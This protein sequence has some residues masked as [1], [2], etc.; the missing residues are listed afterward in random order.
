MLPSHR[1]QHLQGRTGDAI[2]KYRPCH[3]LACSLCM[4]AL[5]RILI[6]EAEIMYAQ[7]AAAPPHH[8]RN[9]LHRRE[10]FQAW[11]KDTPSDRSPFQRTAWSM[12]ASAL[13]PR[14][15]HFCL[16]E[17][18]SS[19]ETKI[20]GSLPSSHYNSLFPCCVCISLAL[21]SLQ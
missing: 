3:D 2:H 17:R 10:S 18:G 19:W 11:R 13:P 12:H 5:L 15:S 9:S 1:A 7:L 4:S 21:A 8:F 14:V 16:V 20:A 6:K